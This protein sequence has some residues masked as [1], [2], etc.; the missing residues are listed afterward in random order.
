VTRPVGLSAGSLG[1]LIAWLVGLAI[2]R[3]TGATPVI[4]VLAAGF[5]LLL[6][7]V[8]TG[9]IALR[10]VSVD[11]VV[12]PPR[13]NQ[14]DE[15]RLVADVRT[16]R[17]VW[18]E[19]RAGDRTVASGWTSNGRFDAA[20]AFVVRGVVD[21]LDVRAASAGAI[22]LVWWR[23][24]LDVPI[25]QHVVAPRPIAGG[26]A[27]VRTSRGSAGDRAGS[28]GS[29]AGEID[30]VRPWRE[31]DSEKFVHWGSTLRAGELIVHDRRRAVD[32]RWLVRARTG[33]PDPDAEAG[34]ARWA[35]ERGLRLGAAVDV[36]IE[37]G[38]PVSIGDVDGAARWTALADLGDQPPPARPARGL[39]RRWSEPETTAP[40]RARWWAAGA[41]LVSLVMLTGALGYGTTVTVLVAIGV[42]GAAAV[43]ARS[44]ATGEPATPLVRGLV[45]GGAVM[46]LGLVA[47]ASGRVDGLLG[48]LRGPLPQVL[49]ILIALHGFECRDR[50][51]VRVG[52]GISAVVL[53]YAAG[54]R[55]DGAVGWWLAA[56]AVCF[57]LALGVLDR[58]VVSDEGGGSPRASATRARARLV[59]RSRRLG[60]RAAAFGVCLVLTAAVLS[61]VPVPD[62]PARLTLPTFIE[63][64]Q[65]ISTPGAI[66]GPDGAVRS[67]GDEGADG[68]R[69]PIGQAGGYTG[70]AQSMDTSVRGDLGDQVVMRVRAP[71]PDYWRGQTFGRFDGR[72]W[73]A[74]DEI[75]TPLTGPNIDV[76]DAL[77][78]TG[79]PGIE[80]ERFIQTF[81]VEEDMPNVVFHAYRPV[82]VIVDADVWAR[83]DGAIR[84]STVFDAGS[85]YTVVSARPRVD[86]QLLRAQGHIGPQLTSFGQ[87][88]FAQYLEVP[89]TTTP[90]TIE[91]ASQLAAGA[92]ST[93][94][95]VRAYEAWMSRNV[96]YDLDAPLP[97]TGEDAVHDFLVDTQ[98]GF[99]EQIAS[100]LTVMLRSQGVPA[101]LATGYVSGQRDRI[102]GVFEVRASDAHAWVEV[103]FPETGW[104][105]FDPTAAVPLSANAGIDSVGADL[106]RALG[107]YAG[108][109]PLE[110][111]VMVGAVVGGAAS[112]AAI[113]EL[114]RRRRRGRWGLLQDRFSDAAQRRGARA[115]AP[116]PRLAAAWTGADDDVARAVAA[117]LDRVAFDPSFSDDD[118]VYDETRRLVGSLPG[119]GGTGQQPD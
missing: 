86:E 11:R 31:G 30:G 14:G 116:N 26:A 51:T 67:A 25:G 102:T 44:L 82:Q 113:G 55:V 63:N 66:V 41:T 81:F 35:I 60:A 70:F 38:D 78:A 34:A 99:C 13:S 77:G 27:I 16:A 33:R 45:A 119:G 24:S 32:E 29:I 40:I 7:A 4:I 46:S 118:A 20:G 106:V 84:S 109:R 19:M 110:L 88:V 94:D 98:L 89:A 6:A 18:I 79:T 28:A 101:R 104:Q 36:A 49:I 105:A 73:Y 21:A 5:V 43:S 58:P 71:E 1:L 54:F 56:W 12:L 42:L 47:A 108:E 96:E 68:R 117:R 39:A 91:L 95:V 69:A 37:D 92:E 114:R 85:I 80:V 64:V 90:E 87:E 59:G 76:P 57:G 115:G 48:V 97:S 112:F 50:R 107:S 83:R 74:D 9:Y 72:R 8:P 2:G 23:R 3:L 61:V 17:P 111:A 100:A 15:V 103:W 93:Y 65:D 22:G 10:R 53:M 75:G 52:L 62:G